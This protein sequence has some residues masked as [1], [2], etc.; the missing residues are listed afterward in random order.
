MHWRLRQ[1]RMGRITPI[2]FLGGGLVRP[3]S[4]IAYDD[5]R[6][7]CSNARGGI[8]LI[9]ASGA[10]E[11]WLGD[12]DFTYETAQ[13]GP[14][15]FIAGDAVNGLVGIE[16]GD[17][18]AANIGRGRVEVFSPGGG[19]RTVFDS[20]AGVSLGL[21]NHVCADPRERLWVTISMSTP[22]DPASGAVAVSANGGP[23]RLAASSLHGANEARVSIDGD[24]LFVSETAARRVSVFAIGADDTLAARR[25]F[26]PEDLGG[27]PDGIAVAAD[28]AVWGVLIGRDCIF[29][30]D[31]D[32]SFD[33]LFVGGEQTWFDRHDAALANGALSPGAAIPHAWAA[34]PLLSSLCFIGGGRVAA[35][36][37]CGT[38]LALFACDAGGAPVHA[39][40]QDALAR[41][42]TDRDQ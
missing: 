30:I 38:Q 36:S 20:I 23:L 32:G 2:G 11:H 35:G 7:A 41:A 3:E 26:G 25:T 17:V 10:V 39:W 5:A 22:G 9:A 14:L 6:L 42:L 1:R 34:A 33:L 12:P 28:G 27:F 4:V 16:G 31:A 19:R 40:P 8:T 15:R 37:L 24:R 13:P 29:R 21:V 18:L